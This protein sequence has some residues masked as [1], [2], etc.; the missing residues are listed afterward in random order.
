MS[1]IGPNGSDQ[2]PLTRRLGGGERLLE[3]IRIVE[4]FDF[5]GVLGGERIVE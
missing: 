3:E 1:P 2:S 5:D 4:E